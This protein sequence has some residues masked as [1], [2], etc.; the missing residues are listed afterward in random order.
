[1]ESSE[2]SPLR[3]QITWRCSAAAS[4]IGARANRPRR[5][6]FSQ[7]DSPDCS[8]AGVRD[9]SAAR[10]SRHLLSDGN[11]WRPLRAPQLRNARRPQRVAGSG[12][13]KSL[14]GALFRGGAQSFIQSV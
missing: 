2:F 14:G 11:K 7:F 12:Q 3:K 5:Q 4:A 6:L 10:L 9:R 1:M 8:I 13:R